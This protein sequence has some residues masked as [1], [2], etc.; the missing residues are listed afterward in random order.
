MSM[1]ILIR[2][3]KNLTRRLAAVCL[4]FA[5]PSPLCAAVLNPKAS[6][7][8]AVSADFSWTD[9]GS[10]YNAV[11]AETDSFSPYVSSITVSGASRSYPG[12]SSNTT[13]YFRI[14][15]TAA[16]D[17]AYETVSTATLAAAPSGIYFNSAGFRSSLMTGGIVRLGWNTGGNHPDTAYQVD[18]AADNSFTGAV[19]TDRGYPPVDIGGLDANTTYY[20]RVRAF[21]RTGLPTPYSAHAATATLAL[22]LSGINTAVYET[23]ASVSW[24]ALSDHLTP[25]LSSEGSRLS[26]SLSQLMTPPLPGWS[27][28][29]PDINSTTLTGLDPNTTYY[30]TVGS[31]NPYGAQNPDYVRSFTTLSARPANLRFTGTGVSSQTATLGWTALPASPASASAD[32][33]RLEASYSGFT[34]ADV[35]ISTATGDIRSSTLTLSGL[36]ANTTYYFRAASLNKNSDPNYSQILSS[37]TLAVPLSAGLLST[38]PA[39]FTLTVNILAPLP[40]LP[41]RSTCEGYL[42]E[43]SSRPFGSGS[44]VYSSAS[45]TNFTNSLAVSGLRPNTAYNLRIATLNWARN[46]NFTVLPATA[47]S[48][49]RALDPVPVSGV[50][51]SSVSVSFASLD[52]DGYILEAS[53]ESFFGSIARSSATADAAATGLTVT[54]L[55]ENTLYYFRAGALY[56][57]ATT[58][59]LATPVRRYTLPLPLTGTALAGVFHTSAAVSWTHLPAASQKT[60]AESYRLEASTSPDFS[61]PALTVSTA[62]LLRSS[63]TVQNLLPNTSYY[64]RAGTMNMDGAGNYAYAPST[65]TL[66]NPAIQAAFSDFAPDRL[67]VNWL[68]NSN[69]PDTV[70]LVR[71]SSHSDYS[72][73]VFSSATTNTYAA[74]TGLSPNTTYYPEM[75]VLNRQGIREGPYNFTARATLAYDPLFGAFSGV[76]TSSVTLNW[77]CAPNQPGDTD[78]KAEISSSPVFAPPVLSAVTTDSSR[79]FGGLVSNATYYMRVSAVNRTG[80]ATAPTSL[81]QALTLPATAYVLSDTG[82]FSGLMTDGFTIN[83]AANGNTA[84]TVYKVSLSRYNTGI[85]AGDNLAAWDSSSSATV[86]GLSCSFKDLSLGATYWAGIQAIGRTGIASSVVLTS[87]VTTLRSGQAGAFASKGN[88][89]TLQASYGLISVFIPAG[90]LGGYARITIEPKDSFAPPASAVSALLPTGIGLEISRFPPVLILNPVTITLPYRFSDLPAGIDPSRLVLAMYDDANGV[91][92]PLPSVSYPAGNKVTAQTWHLSTFQLMQAAAPASLDAVRIY[93]NPYTPSSV[94]DVMHFANMPPYA[95]VRIYT[96]LGELVKELSADVNGMAYWDGKNSSGQKAVSGVY[97]A[98]LRTSDKS[99]SRTVKVVIER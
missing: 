4:F 72:S 44:V 68:P 46:P 3:T 92:V 70:Y 27:T 87:T 99:S 96:F 55:D 84:D 79:T 76:G 71:F 34:G 82:T 22:S 57:E 93:P 41:Q 32:G 28:D 21:S 69:P 94:A 37:I 60:G 78:Y 31:L 74:F 36:D 88:T 61:G 39:P 30:Y 48:M 80:D 65:A 20:F 59:T 75:T 50:W 49:G 12:L 47:T 91:W 1:G 18:Y 40:A 56:H 14:K 5:A 25:A 51:Q 89:V 64:F 24:S 52:S 66:A 81:G 16:P 63:L 58:Y 8:T 45:G 42:L 19:A 9:D 2:A 90:S 23:S 98:L 97:I 33:Y 67:R 6:D 95:K 62:D 11:L 77:G 7:V 13:Y 26:L 29:D 73:A 85:S 10:A 38:V 35:F 43:A 17:S 83:W 86:T 53:T 15:R 54:G